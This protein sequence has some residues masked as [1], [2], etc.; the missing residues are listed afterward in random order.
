MEGGSFLRATG[1]AHGLCEKLSKAD[2]DIP[3]ELST[4]DVNRQERVD[5]IG[6]ASSLPFLPPSSPLL[7]VWISMK[8]FISILDTT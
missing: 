6:S 2:D 5:E 3:V 4:A 1:L 8:P 7:V